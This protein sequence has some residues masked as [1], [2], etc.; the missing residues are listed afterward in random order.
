MNPADVLLAD[1][2]VQALHDELAA[3]PKPGLVSPID[4][5]S[6]ADMDHA[7]MTR[8]AD[9]LHQPFV[10]LAAAGRQEMPF[11][12]VLRPLGIAAE[13]RMLAATGGVNTHRGAIFC[14]GLVVAAIARAETRLSSPT[15]AQV[16]QGLMDAWGEAL[17]RHAA[18]GVA[19]ES[20]GG[21]VRRTL[22]REGARGEAAAGFPGLFDVALP[23]YRRALAAGLDL[24][25]ARIQT[26]FALMAAVDDTTVLHRGGAAADAF[27]RDRARRFL[28][29][30]G[31]HAENWRAKAEDIHRQFVARRLSAGGCADL[32]AATLL[33]AARCTS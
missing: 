2:A 4:S 28:D 31:C 11:E 1:A 13:R 9:A 33:V 24:N 30:G 27:V 18:D 25:A 20:H 29:Q 8:S 22:G 23:T 15:A 17:T 6:H 19:T 12:T 26:L 21:Q 14:L 7:L 10:D 5:G 16:R 32:L 3:Y